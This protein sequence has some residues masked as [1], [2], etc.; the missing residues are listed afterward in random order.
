MLALILA[1]ATP[2]PGAVELLH[3]LTTRL[4]LPVVSTSEREEM[5]TCS[6]F[7]VYLTADTWTSHKLEQ[8]DDEGVGTSTSGLEK[9]STDLDAERSGEFADE[10]RMA[11]NLAQN[12]RDGGSCLTLLLAHEAPGTD[13]DVR[14]ACEFDDFFQKGQ[15]PADLVS[16]GI[17]SSIAT[18]LKG[19]EWRTTSLRMLAGS[20]GAYPA[21]NSRMPRTLTSAMSTRASQWSQM[22]KSQRVPQGM[23]SQRMTSP[24]P[25]RNTHGASS[26][27]L[28]R[29]KASRWS[30]L[31]QALFKRPL[32]DSH[33]SL[34]DPAAP[35]VPLRRA[36]QRDVQA[37]VKVRSGN[38]SVRIQPHF[39]SVSKSCV[40]P[41]SSQRQA[42]ERKSLSYICPAASHLSTSLGVATKVHQAARKP[43]FAGSQPPAC[44]NPSQHNVGAAQR[45]KHPH[46][47]APKAFDRGWEV[48]GLKLERVV[49]QGAA[50]GRELD[51]M[52]WCSCDARGP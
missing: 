20:M 36:D 22:M 15:T 35:E 21:H 40:P 2:T 49:E 41:P 45:L 24:R 42:A 48:K 6:F 37:S 23:T 28:L 7:L 3:D 31:A 12:G 17:Y 16:D 9:I 43:H 46:Q 13:G 44:H 26:E 5:H 52:P 50:T 4:Q 32:G 14:R 11:M 38:M 39:E 30:A 10:V 34:S 19:A 51:A 1:L 33:R 27:Q 18:A 47:S 25:L 8:Q 29:E